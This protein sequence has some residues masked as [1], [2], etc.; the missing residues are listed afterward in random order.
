MIVLKTTATTALI[1]KGE[2]KTVFQIWH[3]NGNVFHSVKK[4]CNLCFNVGIE[5]HKVDGD[6]IYYS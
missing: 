4:K 1:A 2:A 3:K 6:T 5:V